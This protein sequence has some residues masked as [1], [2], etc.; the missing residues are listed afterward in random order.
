M[1]TLT[2]KAVVEYVSPMPL[3]SSGSETAAHGES[4]IERPDEKARHLISKIT[5]TRN[6]LVQ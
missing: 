3:F 4:G 6:D 2:Y 5:R 1:D